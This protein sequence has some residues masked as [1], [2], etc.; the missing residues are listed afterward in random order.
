MN[1]SRDILQQGASL[2]QIRFNFGQLSVNT[3][4]INPG[5]RLN[6]SLFR[7]TAAQYFKPI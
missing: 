7:W 5:Q 3:G 1:P 6:T 4:Q 2:N